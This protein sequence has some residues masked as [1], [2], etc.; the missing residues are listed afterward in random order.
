MRARIS[1]LAAIPSGSGVGLEVPL[2]WWSASYVVECL[3][4]GGVPPMWWSASYVVEC[5]LRGGL[6]PTWCNVV[7]SCGY[8]SDDVGGDSRSTSIVCTV[9]RASMHIHCV[10]LPLASSTSIVC[11]IQRASMP[12]VAL[13]GTYGTARFIVVALRICYLLVCQGSL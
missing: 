13:M 7:A 10:A 8:V 12:G 1:L 6:P 4:R 2:T 11:T 3:L 5:L 9:Q